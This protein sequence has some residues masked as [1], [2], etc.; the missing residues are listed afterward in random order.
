MPV[1][2]A[3]QVGAIHRREQGTSGPWMM[4]EIRRGF[5]V[6]VRTSGEQIAQR[7]ARPGGAAGV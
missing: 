1:A 7:N 3:A 2:D 5:S 4:D 6:C